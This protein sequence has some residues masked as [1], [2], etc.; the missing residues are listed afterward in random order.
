MDVEMLLLGGVAWF[1]AIVFV[2]ASLRAAASAD[3]STHGAGAG[4]MLATHD[5][6]AHGGRDT[7]T[8]E[9]PRRLR[10]TASRLR[11]SQRGHLEDGFKASAARA[12]IARG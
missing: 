3:R 9:R 2:L 8:H 7:A 10:F 6:F 5:P 11:R 12:P 4:P 1:G